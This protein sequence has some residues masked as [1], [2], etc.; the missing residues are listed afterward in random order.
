MLYLFTLLATLPVLL[1]HSQ[2]VPHIYLL[3]SLHLPPPHPSLSP[4]SISEGE[5]DQIEIDRFVEEC[6]K[7]SSFKHAHVMGLIGICFE[8]GSTPFLIMPYMANGS[9][10]R[11]LRRERNSIVILGETE[12][13]E[14]TDIYPSLWY[15]MCHISLQLVEVRKRLMVMCCQI[16]SGMQYLAASKYI[17]RDLAARN[18]M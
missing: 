14:V 7:M 12:E 10:L 1:S 17:H 9:L 8:S 18:C 11:Y 5:F 16:A 6:L 4:L 3:L 2:I 13:D 15:W